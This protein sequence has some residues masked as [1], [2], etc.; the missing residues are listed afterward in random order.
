MELDHLF[1]LTTAT[2]PELE[3][4]ASLGLTPTYRRTHTGQGTANVCFAFSNAFLEVLWM[5]DARDAESPSV[6]RLQLATRAR[7]RSNGANPFGIAWR[8]ASSGEKVEVATWPCH[9]PYLPADRAIDVA[10]DSDDP[11]QPLLF[12][13]PGSSAPSTWPAERRGALQSTGGYERLALQTLW[14]PPDV[15][16]GVALR[17]VADALDARIAV[18]PDGA[19]AVDVTLTRADGAAPLTVR[20]P[21]VVAA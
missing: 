20:L 10:L 4:L 14:L 12:T 13:F 6:A 16:P 7:W 15:L 21:A 19:Y 5:T 3:A 17:R 18:H 1:F 8:P 2:A 9:P 11:R